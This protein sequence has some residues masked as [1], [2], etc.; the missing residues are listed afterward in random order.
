MTAPDS[1]TA[2]R[3]GLGIAASEAAFR[4]ALSLPT[5]AGIPMVVLSATEGRPVWLRRRWTALQAELATQRGAAHIV[6]AGSGH[7][8][9][10]DRPSLVAE[11]I[12]RCGQ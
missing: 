12:L 6:V 1:A 3:E 5:A 2:T 11:A 4:Q 9:H 7:A 10:L 8:V